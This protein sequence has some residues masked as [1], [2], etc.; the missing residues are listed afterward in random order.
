MLI[1]PRRLAVSLVLVAAM[2]GCSSGED[3]A[4]PTVAPG[5]PAA[6]AA[7][8][9]T[10]TPAAPSEPAAPAVRTIDVAFEAGKVTGTGPRVEVALGEKVIIRVRSDVAEEVHVHG[11]DLMAD[12]AAGG[13]AEI[14]LTASIPGGFEVELEGLGKTLFQLRVS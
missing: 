1:T 7:P 11:Y 2:A 10:A 8:A 3:T 12:V 5:T 4:A 6:S 14:P 9:D 13:T